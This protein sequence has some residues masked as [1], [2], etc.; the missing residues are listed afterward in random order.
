[1][2]KDKEWAK[3]EVIKL[4]GRWMAGGDTIHELNNSVI[5]IIDKLDELEKVVIP[6]FVADYI[7]LCKG[8]N[9]DKQAYTEDNSE[10]WF[11]L[12]GD[13]QGM[14]NSVS[15]WLFNE[16]KVETFARAWLDGYEVEK[17]KLYRVIIP[18]K[19]KLFKYYYLDGDGG[20]NMVNKLESVE[21]HTEEF[22][23]SISDDLWQFA[24]EVEG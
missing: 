5:S 11:A 10:L 1:M 7:E 9:G 6:R 19:D 16:E 12:N 8:E 3:N 20:I 15:D 21:S 24:V 14:P 17:E 23:R 22:I 2:R 13:S 4:W 18:T